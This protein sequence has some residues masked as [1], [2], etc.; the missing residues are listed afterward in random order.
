[1]RKIKTGGA[2]RWHSRFY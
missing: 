1:M 2:T